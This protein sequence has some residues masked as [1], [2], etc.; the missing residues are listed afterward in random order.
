M[1]DYRTT[2]D[3]AELLGVTTDTIRVYRTHSK[4]GGRYETHPFP[5]PDELVGRT[6]I[7]QKTRD[8]E[9]RAWANAR[10]GQ[11]KGGGRPPRATMDREPAAAHPETPVTVSTAPAVT[12]VGDLNARL[13]AAG[14]L[15]PGVQFAYEQA[16]D[17]EGS[18]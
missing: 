16:P 10:P 8:D 1:A 15:P 12:P 11:G 3:I 17:N 4:P 6:P 5:E 7:W 13:Q 14:I 18:T 9:I 2:A